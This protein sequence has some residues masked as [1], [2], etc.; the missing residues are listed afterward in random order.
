MGVMEWEFGVSRYKLLYIKWLNNKVLLYSKKSKVKVLVAQS[1]PT[2][3]DPMNCSPPGSF[4]HGI[5]QARILEWVAIPFSRRSFLPGI[6]PRSP[7]LQADSLL[8]E[9]PGKPIQ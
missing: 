1:C 3:C 8:S 2:L 7:K 5:L 4:V 6:E 9:P